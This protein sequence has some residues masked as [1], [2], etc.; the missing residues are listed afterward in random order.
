MQQYSLYSDFGPSSLSFG[1]YSI[2]A[3][4]QLKDVLI[5]QHSAVFRCF[6]HFRHERGLWLVNSQPL[7]EVGQDETQRTGFVLVMYLI[8][9]QLILT[10]ICQDGDGKGEIYV[11]TMS[12][13][14]SSKNAAVL[15][16]ASI[17]CQIP[18]MS[19]PQW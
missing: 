16:Y 10:D 4:W 17:D 14:V 15:M 12:G 18:W 3:S 11:Q 19:Q 7:A 1:P 6:R 2:S 8:D 13:W 5:R 9:S